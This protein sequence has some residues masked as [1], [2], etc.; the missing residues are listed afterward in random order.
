V[1]GWI[2][3]LVTEPI[4]HLINNCFL[5]GVFPAIFKF[6]HVI[7][8]PKSSDATTP[9]DFRP[10]ST[11]HI[12]SKV[13]EKVAQLQLL[14]HLQRYSLLSS[15]Q[16]GF[17]PGYSCESLLLKLTEKWKNTMDEGKVTAVAFLDLSKAFD[18]VCH[19]QLLEKLQLIGADATSMRW[20]QS[21]LTGR[22]Q[23]VCTESGQS[24]I[25]PVV[26][27]VPQGS[28]LG[29]IL[30]SI[31]I[32]GMLEG[33]STPGSDIECFADDT[34]VFAV[35]K[36]GEEAVQRLNEALIYPTKWLAEHRLPAN[37]KKTKLLM[38]YSIYTKYLGEHQSPVTMAGEI[39]E[40]VDSARLLGVV[41]DSHLRWENQF[42]AV[43]KSVTFG[44][45]KLNRAK[46]GLSIQQR[47]NLYHALIE[48]HFDYCS[49]VWSAANVSFRTDMEILQRRAIKAV[50]NY[51][52]D[53][54][55]PALFARLKITP[56]LERWKQ[57]EATWLYK[58]QSSSSH[59]PDYMKDLLV[60]KDLSKAYY[61]RRPR[62]IEQ[63]SQRKPGDFT[64]AARLKLLFRG[65]PSDLWLCESLKS[66]RS[67]LSVFSLLS[68]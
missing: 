45:A 62:R 7:P 27:G 36:D 17:R 29:P 32:N 57:A 15:R 33:P 54:I 10:V 4:T 18:S 58:I 53:D 11:L 25:L 13:F 31:Y 56:V 49:P 60:F 35:G 47:V 3:P 2:V 9:D 42:K 52:H 19:H 41:F 46:A 55:P 38:I 43:T 34:N 14:E 61:L 68:I 26:S 23:K 8:I 39:L 1:L 51:Q 24:D 21:Y 12:I 64:L 65:L 59:I 37:A 66:F 20:F 40:E 28:V 50:T 5:N 6:A 30:F 67:K 63:K 44:I 22:S 48:P 16:S